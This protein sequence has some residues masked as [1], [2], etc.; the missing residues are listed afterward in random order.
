MSSSNVNQKHVIVLEVLAGPDKGRLITVDQEISVI[1]RSKDCD[2]VIN[3]ES[4]S[5]EHV[6][7]SISLINPQNIMIK[8]LGSRNG[9]RVNGID[10]LETIIHPGEVLEL[11][12]SFLIFKV[13]DNPEEKQTKDDSRPV[14]F[15]DRITNDDL[16]SSVQV[17]EI[18][19]FKL[20]S[21]HF[22]RNLLDQRL[23]ILYRLGEIITSR[24]LLNEKL[25][26]MLNMVF[27]TIPA[28]S[29]CILTVDPETDEYIVLAEQYASV[30]GKLSISKTIIQKVIA[31][32]IG[33]LMQDS[34]NDPRFDKVESIVQK[35]LRSALAVPVI[36][37]NKVLGVIFLSTTLR[38]GIFQDEDLQFVSGLANEVALVITHHRMLDEQIAKEK[39]AEV[40]EL[41][42]GL[43]HYIK[44]ILFAFNAAQT[45]ISESLEMNAI[46]DVKEMWPIIINHSKIISDLVHDML[47]FARNRKLKLKEINIK[48]VFD[49]VVSLY[50]SVARQE[51][52]ELHSTVDD[53]VPIILLDRITLHRVLINLVKNAIDALKSQKNGSITLSAR[54]APNRKE[55][56]IS[57]KDTGPGISREEQKKIFRYLYSTKGHEG[58]G[59]GLS[60]SRELIE[61]HNGT[62]EVI[63]D[64]GEGAEFVI[65]LP[66][67]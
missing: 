50:N 45:L 52:I 16:V 9:I 55:L 8:D 22:K 38:L 63:S 62:L 1:G 40:G 48:A 34:H 12:R 56:K 49:E 30:T 17:T 33:V 42:T 67:K 61:D 6:R 57:V 11:G 2:I 66:L 7:V 25:G 10:L 59:L 43:S 39:M 23:Q 13:V 19:L 15:Y 51:S 31:E 36:F 46:D 20:D 21:E 58:T 3:D 41:I 14:E 27:D 5:R 37:E 47:H 44:N 28:E 32:R 4:V 65:L 18:N 64:V 29:G 53:D 54:V 35:N 26:Q 24:A 60:I